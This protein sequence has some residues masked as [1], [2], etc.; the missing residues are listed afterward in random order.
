MNIDNVLKELYLDY[1]TSIVMFD[2]Q[3]YSMLLA[4]LMKIDFEPYYQEDIR[5]GADGLELRN[6]FASVS[7]VSNEKF[8][9]DIGYTSC[10]MLEMMV[11]LSL[12]ME[13]I[14]ADQ[15][16]N[17]TNIWFKRMLYSLGLYEMTDDNFNQEYIMNCINKF[18]N[19]DYEYNG[20]GGLFT[21]NQPTQDIRKLEIWNQ[22]NLY[23]VEL[24]SMEHISI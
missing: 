2:R 12:R 15:V 4:T 13:D 17:R 9:Q 18:K 11:A 22:M 8:I 6:H 5:R 14:M 24:D 3:D 1:L 7:N 21:L 10:S 20:K 16:G 19:V 23:I